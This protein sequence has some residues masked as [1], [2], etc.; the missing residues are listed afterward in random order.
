VVLVPRESGHVQGVYVRTSGAV[1]SLSAVTTKDGYVGRKG[2]RHPER[3]AERE[4]RRNLIESSPS[5]YEVID[6]RRWLV[7]LLPPPGD[8][9]IARVNY[10]AD[11]GDDFGA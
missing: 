10:L 6:G 11:E 9:W 3:I 8:L 5:R 4:H 1:H 7:R 2:F